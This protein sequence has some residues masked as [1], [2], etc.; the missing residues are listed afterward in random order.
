[1]SENGVEELFE[2]FKE[3]KRKMR[4]E[5]IEDEDEPERE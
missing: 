3:K 4:K 2:K 5:L 1:M